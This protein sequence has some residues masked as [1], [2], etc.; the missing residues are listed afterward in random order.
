MYMYY[1]T[2]DS[3][4]GL[5]IVFLGVTNGVFYVKNVL[6]MQQICEHS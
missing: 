5:T 1:C 4:F 3:T 6:L 2:Y